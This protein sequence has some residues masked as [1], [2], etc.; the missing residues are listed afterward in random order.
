M[1]SSIP[2][3]AN[4]R[5]P[6]NDLLQWLV[7]TLIGARPRVSPA[8]KAGVTQGWRMQTSQT[9]RVLAEIGMVR[10]KRPFAAPTRNW[11]LPYRSC[12]SRCRSIISALALLIPEL[13]H[14]GIHIIRAVAGVY[15][16]GWRRAGN[17]RIH[18]VVAVPVGLHLDLLWSLLA[19]AAAVMAAL[20]PPGGQQ[21]G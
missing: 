18:A 11:P 5:L 10:P 3:H 2:L 12:W 16:V 1:A 21:F 15:P 17:R 4:R 8:T 20:L 9:K 7:L 19:V 6:R 14:R 13:M